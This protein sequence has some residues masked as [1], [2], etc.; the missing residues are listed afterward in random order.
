MLV[1]SVAMLLASALLVLLASAGPAAPAAA[2]PDPADLAVTKTDSPDPVT[3]G[4][5][6]TYTI[7]VSNTDPTTPDA[8]TNVIVTDDLKSRLDF[9]SATASS[10]SCQGPTGQGH[11][12]KVTCSLGT[13]SHDTTATVTII[14]TPNKAGTV[15]NTASVSSDTTDPQANNNS[16]TESTT[17]I[18]APP[19]PT[20]FG[21]EVTIVGT[22]G[23]DVLTG[24][25]GKDV[26]SA[27]A[28]RD[29]IFGLGGNDL[30]CS[31]G[32]A[33][34]V[35]AGKGNDRVSGG[36]GR[37]IL[38]G[39]PGNDELRGRRG[40]DRMRGNAGND[41][42]RGGHGRDRCRGGPGS[43]TLISCER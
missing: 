31:R 34:F 18:E 23:D 39:R 36:R 17:V 1:A 27:R 6:L 40:R 30:L 5:Q 20:C 33:D 37:D 35:D 4:A 9:V 3:E 16:D 26:I 43:D 7:N 24:T 28:G 15:N 21:Q 41:L 19:G 14:V 13:V 29:Q 38:K 25:D 11:G 22:S 32:G 2:A 42:L 8:A 10:G 12:G